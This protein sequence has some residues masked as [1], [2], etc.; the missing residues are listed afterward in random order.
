MRKRIKVKPSKAQSRIAI[1]FCLIF[2]LFGI[3]VAIPT[4]GPFG[5]VWTAGVALATFV[6]F[7]NGFTEDG[8]PTKEIIIEDTDEPIST[9]DIESRLTQLD[10]LYNKGLISRD[11]YDEKRREILNDL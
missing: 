4:F 10:S 8:V 5:I 1:V 11:E 6:S 3:F 9:N 2:C 7:K